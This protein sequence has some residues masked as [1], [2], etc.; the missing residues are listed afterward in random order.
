MSDQDAFARILASLCDATLDDRH[1]PV[2]S[3]LIDE[4]CGI[5]GNCLLVGEGPP[6]DIRAMFVGVYARGER[7]AD[8]E[9]EYLQVYHPL[10]EAVPRLRQLPDSQVVPIADLYTA[11]ELKRSPSYNDILRRAHYQ[12]GLNVRLDGP[13]RSHMTW[14]LGDPVASDGWG[15]AKIALLQRLLPQIRQFVCVRQALVRA[16]ARATTAGALLENPRIGVIHLD[17]RGQIL[18]INDRARSLLRPGQGLSDR[19]GVL[20][21]RQPADQRRL[22]RLVAGALPT[23][24]AVPVSGSMLLARAAGAPPFVVHVKPVAVPQP[25]YGARYVAALVLIDRAEE[26]ASDRPRP[27]GQDPGADPDGESDCGRAGRRQE[28]AG[29]GRGHGAHPRR[30]L[31]APEEDLPETADLRAGGSGAAGAVTHRVRV[32]RHAVA[33]S[34]RPGSRPLSAFSLPNSPDRVVTCGA[35]V[36]VMC[37][38]LFLRPSGTVRRSC[39]SRAARNGRDVTM[40]LEAWRRSE[41]R[42]LVPHPR[43]PSGQL[44]HDPGVTG[45]AI[46]RPLQNLATFPDVCG[47]EGGDPVGTAPSEN[48]LPRRLYALSRGQSTGRGSSAHARHARRPG[49]P[50]DPE[51]RGSSAR[52]TC[53][54]QQA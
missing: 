28:R 49:E 4:A 27:G 46:C 7:Q 22:E 21:T 45:D 47:G 11:E 20:R 30:H 26:P 23:A 2:T 29:A 24:G 41:P 31:L 3:A 34:G 53:Q 48:R 43:P 17:R 44:A 1:W 16:G 37:D 40:D 42:Q 10:D 25:D 13:D 32:N 51:P 18:E 54:T 19:D 8:L 12:Q 35:S 15:S 14:G 50:F 39:R 38:W 9:R 36:R 33:S 52:S 6:D 5:T